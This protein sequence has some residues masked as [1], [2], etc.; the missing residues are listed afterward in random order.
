VVA[1][2]AVGAADLVC[3]AISASGGFVLR[4]VGTR[5]AGLAQ[6]PHNLL[7]AGQGVLMLFG[8][9]DAGHRAYLVFAVLHL[10][11]VALAAIAFVL[12]LARFFRPG[13]LL[14]PALA[15][16]IAANLLL[17]SYGRY[18]QNLLST[19]EITD[20]LPFGAALAGRLLAGPLLTGWGSRVRIGGWNVLAAALA[21]VLAGYAAALVVYSAQPPAQ[22]RNQAL[23]GWLVAHHLGDGLSASY[24][25]ADSTTADSGGR[26]AVREVQIRSGLLAVPDSGWGYDREWY[27]ARSQRAG[28]VV[29]SDPPGSGGWRSV[30]NSARRTFGRP[31]RIYSYRQYTVLV[32]RSNLLAR[33]R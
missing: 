17:Y 22:P 25:L 6:I 18:A 16:A 1:V 23:A 21:A 14:A 8:A 27:L 3:A 7:L 12:A 9:Y 13:Q 29:T 4:P 26:A 30:T 11:G 31:A 24:W 33:L 20:V 28:F 32:W 2:A 15:L 5:F 19:R 10:V